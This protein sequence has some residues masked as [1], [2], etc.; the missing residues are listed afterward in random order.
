MDGLEFQGGTSKTIYF[1]MRMV[2]N[3]GK[4][5]WE[6]ARID[7]V[8]LDEAEARIRQTTNA[9]G[10]KRDLAVLEAMPGTLRR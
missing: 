5:D 9:I 6:T 8:D 3:T 4:F 7:W 1:L 2:E 10:R